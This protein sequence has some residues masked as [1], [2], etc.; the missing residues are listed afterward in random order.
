[1]CPLILT[2]APADVFVVRDHIG[3]IFLN[4][5][6]ARKPC[7]LAE[8]EWRQFM[9]PNGVP[10][11]LSLSVHLPGLLCQYEEL[12]SA[13][14]DKTSGDWIEG[15]C[16]LHQ[17]LWLCLRPIDSGDLDCAREADTSVEPV[18]VLQH[19]YE[20]STLSFVILTSYLL[21]NLLGSSLPRSLGTPRDYSLTYKDV[22]GTENLCRQL[23]IHTK[24]RYFSIK[25]ADPIAAW[26]C[27]TPL[28]LLVKRALLASSRI[29]EHPRPFE[30]ISKDLRDCLLDT[31]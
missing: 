3:T 5:V 4:V 15:L 23:A 25:V 7:F 11:F 22:V 24:R 16:Q 10:N 27:G 19:A 21:V 30:L 9:M 26:A 2:D 17:Q 13:K 14:L 12:R 8:N 20:I 18:D 31:D 28:G 6:Q 1:M 29:G